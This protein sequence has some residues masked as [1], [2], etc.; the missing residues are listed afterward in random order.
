MTVVEGATLAATPVAGATSGLVALQASNEV[1]KLHCRNGRWE[2][3]AHHCSAVGRS[4]LPSP[5]PLPLPQSSHSSLFLSTLVRCR[6]PQGPTHGALL[7]PSV[8]G[9]LL[10]SSQCSSSQHRAAP[11]RGEG[12]VAP[13]PSVPLTASR[14]CCQ[15]FGGA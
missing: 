3:S 12:C 6:G 4:C 13:W 14:D 11:S 7:P 15:Q 1:P 8:S 2:R 9:S 5:P 10:P